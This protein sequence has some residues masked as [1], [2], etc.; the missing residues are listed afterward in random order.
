MYAMKDY[1]RASEADMAPHWP[2]DGLEATGRCPVCGSVGRA[3]LHEGLRDRIFFCAPGEWTLQ[4]CST[5]GSAYLDPRPTVQTI[6]LAYRSYFTHTWGPRKSI[7][8]LT[9]LRRLQRML[10]NGYRNWRFGTDERPANRMGVFIARLLPSQRAMLDGE[11]RHLPRAGRDARLLDVGCGNGSFLDFARRAGWRVVGIDPDREAV[12]VARKKGLDVREGGIELL[13]SEHE[14]F[15]GITLSHVIEHVHQPL[16]LLRACHRLLK[17]GGWIWLET[18][19]LEAQGHRRYGADWRALEPPRHLVL[20]TPDSIRKALATAGFAGIEDQP[21][22]PLCTSL[23]AASEAISKGAD[24]RHAG[25]LSPDGRRAARNAEQRARR[26]PLV[27]EFITV[28]AWKLENAAPDAM[29][30]NG[31]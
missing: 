9:F 16:S 21:Y 30:S 13:D 2:S 24:V 1:C 27:R 23:F 7:E 25:E 4:R 14:A 11:A 26:D 6:G 18:P 17:R 12:D 8:R 19:N 5:C 3:L 28:K 15:D 31:G 29:T 22:R 10:A 20:F